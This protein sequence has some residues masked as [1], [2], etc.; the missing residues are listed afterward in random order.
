MKIKSGAPRLKEVLANPS[1]K[2]ADTAPLM[3]QLKV[4]YRDAF[5]RAKSLKDGMPFLNSPSEFTGI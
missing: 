5:S 4:G 3:Q 1:Y 2:N